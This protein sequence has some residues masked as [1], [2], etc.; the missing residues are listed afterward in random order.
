[1]S[2]ITGSVFAQQYSGSPQLEIL[3]REKA[4]QR[5]DLFLQSKL[6]T[7][8]A[9]RK[10]DSLP[11]YTM[12]VGEVEEH[13]TN[14]DK[15][16]V[17]LEAF[18]QKVKNANPPALSLASVV[19]MAS[20]YYGQI[21]R[22]QQAFQTAERAYKIANDTKKAGPEFLGP[23]LSDIGT[24]AYR[25]GDIALAQS[26][27]RRAVAIF[28]TSKNPDYNSLYTAANNM[29]GQMW[30]ASK[31]DSAQYY[32]NVALDAIMKLDTTPLNQ[33][34]RPG[35]LQNN[36]S[37]LY[38]AQGNV[39][40]AI[41]AMVSCIANVRKYL[42][43]PETTPKR[44][45]SESFLYEA[46]DNLGG[47]Y[48]DLGDL[49]Q[50]EGL[51]R[52]SYEQKLRRKE[53]EPTAVYKSEILLGQLYLAMR[54]HDKALPLL[55][56]G[57]D[58]ISKSDD[59]LLFWQADACHSIALLYEQK[60]NIGRAAEFYAKADSLYEASLQGEYDDIY[61]GFLQ[62]AATFY[63]DNGQLQTGIAKANKGLNYI[64]KTQGGETLVAFA[65]L[66]NLADVYL[67]GKMY[68]Q[69]LVYG[70]RAL[71]IVNKRIRA[72][73][74]GLDSIRTELKKPNAI[75]VKVKAEY[76]LME[77][78]DKD[79][80]TRLLK[81]LDEAVA[82]LE[83]RRAILHDANDMN[84]ILEN[85]DGLLQF[86][87]K[88]TLDLY[89][90]TNDA[91]HL[92]R[93]MSLQESAIYS[94]IRSRL[95][96][97]DSIRFSQVPVQVQ[98][99]ERTL[100]TTITAALEKNDPQAM[101]EY[102]VAI[103]EWQ[104]FQQSLKKDYPEYYKMRYEE[105]F[106]TLDDIQR[107]V[108]AN[109]TIIRYFF[110]D[111]DLFA[112]VIGTSQKQLFALTTGNL[113]EQVKLISDYSAPFV[114][115]SDAL[116]KLY[117]ALWA[118]LA[119]S[120][121]TKKVTIIPDG[122]LFNLNFEILTPQPLSKWEDLA[123]VCLLS[124]YTIAYHYSLV[125][126]GQKQHHAGL[127][128]NFVAFAP[129]F[130]DNDKRNYLS[131]VKD[132]F[133]VDRDYVN[134]L[135][136]PFTVDFASRAKGLMNGEAYLNQAST[137]ESFRR[138][139]GQHKIIH[140]GTHAESNNL[141]PEFSRL[142]FA[143]TPTEPAN[144]VFLSEIYDCDL[145]SELAVLTACESGRAGYQDGEG[146]IS[147]AHAFNYAGSESIL[148]GLWKIDEKAS[149]VLIEAFYKNLLDGMD[150]DE[151]LRQA[152]LHYLKTSNGRTLAP[153]YWAGLVLMGDTSP[154]VI[155][156]AKDNKWWWIGGGGV[157]LLALIGI[158]LVRKR[159]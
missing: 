125:L 85:Q 119:S 32:Y 97:S 93:L 18:L 54:D 107:S 113:E 70:K 88:L 89:N 134:L 42:S 122:I 152:K 48:K 31:F 66:N 78:K 64:T 30:F 35:V 146:M 61:L 133:Q 3:L 41:E 154:V 2:C 37:A 72:S 20:E 118:P 39:K 109:S 126:V 153:P 57:L 23:I 99:K 128:G 45:G 106:R 135:P 53:N 43:I 129:G 60:H 132:S 38:N 50:A 21:G 98:Q 144:S 44:A 86:I 101:D 147:L 75:L 84:L 95:D 67:R 55:V 131:S 103:R 90:L 116:Y 17:K 130:L 52:Y 92:D 110:I 77:N 82:L 114:Q 83:K 127:S 145:R 142:I 4:Y 49:S 150:K 158:V 11:S 5:A 159:K 14:V 71:D 62:N 87:K 36:L 58:N 69:A 29:G 40:K 22:N 7:F 139:A 76:Y 157:L 34:Y 120:V 105:I 143:K 151:A 96:K 19:S 123:G 137:P 28:L 56:S 73:S 10:F 9:E 80:L 47:I 138:F 115:T 112:A 46:I 33:Y 94:R 59:D 24:F 68:Q 81:E 6:N 74:N 111:K 26:Y 156:E 63:A 117:R 65:Q 51:L 136:Q 8:F 141:S 25:K 1:M 148:T 155:S 13:L 16:V 102:F 124:K 27:H 91:S 12:Y 79:N 104:N 140:I 15:A 108:P 121:N 100:K 149:T